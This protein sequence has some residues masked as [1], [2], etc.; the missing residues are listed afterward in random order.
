MDTE[1]IDYESNEFDFAGSFSYADLLLI[2][3]R[4]DLC[5]D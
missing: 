1:S 2:T 4:G 3:N 5:Y